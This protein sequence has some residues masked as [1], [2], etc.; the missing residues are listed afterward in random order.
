M[1]A[2]NLK[3]PAD[4]TTFTFKNVEPD[5]E[6]KAKIDSVCKLTLDASPY[7]ST[8]TGQLEK[9]DGDFRCFIKIRSEGGI[10]A[11]SAV[12]KTASDAFSHAGDKLC[13]QLE[14]W[15]KHRVFPPEE[16]FS[17]PSS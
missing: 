12:D 2:P 15:K 5:S 14:N 9:R 11:A 13:E 4:E 8:L 7:G 1:E 17:H 6:L 16:S 10:F 3:N